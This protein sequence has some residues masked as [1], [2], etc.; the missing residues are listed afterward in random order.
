[1][2]L[3]QSK[4]SEK[5]EQKI[6]KFFYYKKKIVDKTKSTASMSNENKENRMTI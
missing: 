4:S 1:M 3:R 5:R 6:Q 2:E